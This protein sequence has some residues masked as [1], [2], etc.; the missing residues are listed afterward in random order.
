MQY[1]IHLYIA[2]SNET[3]A[4][5]TIVI[6]VPKKAREKHSKDG[7]QPK[8]NSDAPTPRSMVNIQG[9]KKTRRLINHPGISLKYASMYTDNTPYSTR[10]PSVP[11]HR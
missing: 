9:A 5:H 8:V 4:G 10:V 11:T 6:P 1:M 7:H 2:S 3:K